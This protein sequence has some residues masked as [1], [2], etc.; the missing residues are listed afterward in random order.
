[1]QKCICEKGNLNHAKEIAQTDESSKATIQHF[2]GSDK[3]T[4]EIHQ[5]RHHCNKVPTLKSAHKHKH[6]HH[7]GHKGSPFK[8]CKLWNPRSEGGPS[9]YSDNTC[10]KCGDSKHQP[11]FYCPTQKFKCQNCHKMGHFTSCCFHRGKQDK[12]HKNKPKDVHGITTQDDENDNNT[13]PVESDQDSTSS[14]ESFFVG[15][16]TAINKVTA[17]DNTIF[18][19]DLLIT[20]KV[21]HK[22]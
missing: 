4:A 15:T 20:T 22:H 18:L 6:K 21:H 12:Y 11:G 9:H 10:S 13:L 16:I 17:H 5:L 8:K 14:N 1:M 19:I 7:Q 2:T 3:G